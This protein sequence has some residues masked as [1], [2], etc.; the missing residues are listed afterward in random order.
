MGLKWAFLIA[1]AILAFCLIQMLFVFLNRD[2][3][4]TAGRLQDIAKNLGNNAE[5]MRKDLQAKES[6]LS[7]LRISNSVRSSI[8]LSGIRVRPEEFVLIWILCIFA[9]ALLVSSFSP[10]LLR[11]LILIVLGAIA[12]PLYLRRKTNKRLVLF[13]RQLGDALMVL[14]NGLRAGLSFQQALHSVA[15]DLP[16]PIGAEF[17]MVGRE[18]Q[19]GVDIDESLTKVAT[20][21]KSKDM[22]LLTTAISVQLQVGGNLADILDTISKTIRERLS[23]RRN[24]RSL[25]AQGRISGMVIGFL[26]VGLLVLLSFINPGYVAPFFTTTVGYVMLGIGVVLEVLGFLVINKIV[27]LKF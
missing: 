7:F 1:L 9:P 3:L 18:L 11:S 4:K 13:E 24:I 15:R 25:T 10:S 5:T 17:R 26:P 27:D 2:K 23:I 22:A 16:D 6:R 12:P 14:S 21:M 19:M 20:R 8:V